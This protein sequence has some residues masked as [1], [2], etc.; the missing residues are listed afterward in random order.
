MIAPAMEAA[1][2]DPAAIQLVRSPDRE[3][4]RALVSCRA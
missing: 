3:A 1:G 4:A 2:L